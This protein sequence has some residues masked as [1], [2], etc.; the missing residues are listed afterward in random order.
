M[1]RILLWTHPS[2]LPHDAAGD[3]LCWRRA[4]SRP[5]LPS[6]NMSADGMCKI[7]HASHSASPAPWSQPDAIWLMSKGR[8]AAITRFLAR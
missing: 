2:Q 4:I 3:A 7:Y 6:C 8:L 5:T 1:V